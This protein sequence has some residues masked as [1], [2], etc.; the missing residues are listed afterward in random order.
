MW[1][2]CILYAKKFYLKAINLRR[3]Y[4]AIVGL[5]AVVAKDIPSMTVFAGNPA[6]KLKD[7]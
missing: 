7:I 6:R 3:D 1:L 2:S 5:G 4:R